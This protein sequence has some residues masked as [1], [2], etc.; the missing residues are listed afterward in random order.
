MYIYNIVMSNEM[1]ACD[2]YYRLAAIHKSITIFFQFDDFS[3][4]FFDFEH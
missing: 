2:I 4:R 3:F 1:L